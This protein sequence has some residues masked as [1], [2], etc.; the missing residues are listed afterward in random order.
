M[1]F[2]LTLL[3]RPATTQV[4][5]NRIAETEAAG[6]AQGYNTTKLADREAI[7]FTKA[8]IITTD[9]YLYFFPENYYKV[10][11]IVLNRADNWRGRRYN[12]PPKN[13]G[14]LIS[15]HSDYSIL[16]HHAEFFSPLKWYA[17]NNDTNK[18]NVIS[19]PLGITNNT[20]E[21]DLHPVYGDLDSMVSIMNQDVKLINLVYMNF[22]INTY[23]QERQI[24]W[25][26]F[27]DKEWVTIGKIINTI[28][29]RT[30][31]LREI[32][33]HS[34]VLCPRGNGIDTHRLWETLYMGSIPIVKK[35]N[36]YKQFYDLPICFVD[37][38]DQITP[39]FLEME[40][41]RIVNSN[42]CLEKLKIG[43]WVEKINHDMNIF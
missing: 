39:E 42:Y 13:M 16:D 33:S 17:T 26:L 25:N 32:K 41:I 12:P 24:V 5:A 18:K 35:H 27:K 31:F 43:Y 7:T 8:D 36:G 1:T 30:N 20:N 10:D 38:W 28:E 15:G 3:R 40:K 9:K 21:S 11:V 19:L 2:T 37:N 14:L 34:F 4:T 23:P 29:G 22:N 6:E